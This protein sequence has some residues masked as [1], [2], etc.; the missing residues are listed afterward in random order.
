MVHSV[1]FFFNSD[2]AYEAQ[3][4]QARLNCV[5]TM[6]VPGVSSWFRKQAIIWDYT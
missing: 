6:F 1:T 3:A 5:E 4:T 2:S